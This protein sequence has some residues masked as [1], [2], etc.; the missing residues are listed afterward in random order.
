VFDRRAL[1]RFG[2]ILPERE[3]LP[4]SASVIRIPIDADY[5]MLAVVLT[6]PDGWTELVQRKGWKT[7]RIDSR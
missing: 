4:A 5:H 3:V 1:R 2:L 7:Y 6:P